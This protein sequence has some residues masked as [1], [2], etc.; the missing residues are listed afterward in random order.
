MSSLTVVC[1][2]KE[3]VVGTKEVGAGE[4]D[5]RD[6]V[7]RLRAGHREPVT[8]LPPTLHKRGTLGHQQPREPARERLFP[9]HHGVPLG[10][11]PYSVPTHSGEGPPLLFFREN[12]TKQWTQALPGLGEHVDIPV[13]L[14]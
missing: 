13:T 4:G 9:A 2:S 1:R 3:G 14:T 11:C 10:G 6:A 12:K 7:C 8:D 5:D